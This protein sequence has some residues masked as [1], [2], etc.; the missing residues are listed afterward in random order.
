MISTASNLTGNIS[1]RVRRL[2]GHLTRRA[3]PPKPRRVLPAAGVSD[4]CTLK[5]R[6][7]DGGGTWCRVKKPGDRR[8]VSCEALPGLIASLRFDKSMR[9]NHS[10]VYFSRPIRWLVALFGEQVI[11]FEYA[12]VHSGNTTRGLRIIDPTEFAVKDAADYFEH[13]QDQGI[14]PEKATVSPSSNPR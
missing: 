12:G 11:P 14:D 5:V 10:N 1:S 13:L 3:H 4:A 2:T 6:E 9:W 7:M 8:S